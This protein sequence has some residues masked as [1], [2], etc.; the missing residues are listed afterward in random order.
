[1]FLIRDPKGS[2]IRKRL[3][4]SLWL[5]VVVVVIMGDEAECND[6]RAGLVGLLSSMCWR[7]P[8]MSEA[9]DDWAAL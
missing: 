9:P 2:S 6:A 8:D 5:V 4:R 7:L 3:F 1:M